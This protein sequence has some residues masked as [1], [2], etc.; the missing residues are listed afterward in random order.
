MPAFLGAGR[1]G[2]ASSCWAEAR[3]ESS[4]LRKGQERVGRG[5]RGLGEAQAALWGAQAEGRGRETSGVTSST[6]P[7]S[8]GSAAPPPLSFFLLPTPYP[9]QCSPLSSGRSENSLNVH[10]WGGGWCGASIEGRGRRG[11]ATRRRDAGGEGIY[12]LDPQQLDS[13]SVYSH[14][15]DWKAE[16]QASRGFDRWIR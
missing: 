2:R 14:F 15:A 7:P 3:A 12:Y 13:P 4:Q 10:V 8:A 5:P 11:Q 16:T 9:C 6:S 1:V